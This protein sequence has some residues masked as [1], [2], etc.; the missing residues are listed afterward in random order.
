M[1]I[2]IDA[3]FLGTGTGLSYYTE[4]LIKNLAKLDDK[5]SYLI[6]LE[7]KYF[8]QFKPPAPNFKKIKINAPHYSLAEQTRLPSL[9]KKLK[10]DLVHFTNFN[11]PLLF[12]GLCVFTIQD[13]ILSVVPLKVN[14]FK[15]W[16]YKL[17]ISSAVRKGK[18]IIVPSM[19][20]K[21]DLQIILKVKSD[22][23]SIIYDGIVFPPPETS[24]KKVNLEKELKIKKPY[25]L[26]VGRFAPH[27]N[28]PRLLE[29]FHLLK[30][31]YNI[32]HQLV[33]VGS[34]DKD[35]LS[36][37]QKVVQL[38]LE[39]AVVFTGFL[40]DE[41]LFERL[42]REASLLVLPS[43]YEGFGLSVLDA[44]S[45]GV[46]IACSEISSLPEIAGKTAQF[47]NPQDPIDIAEKIDAVLNDNILREK[48]I[49]EGLKQY[50]K[51]PWEKTA[52]ETLLV[53]KDV[54]K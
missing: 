26:Y 5:N 1:R 12:R 32:N 22:K 23:I 4:N 47:F 25:I 52:Q 40:K 13:L 39:D 44:M 48:L 17:T 53:Y 9:I 21:K 36:L 6:I 3:R 45:R 33:L 7:N 30:N 15:K 18:K 24:L 43:L 29:A 11:H 42:Y 51:F 50:K 34:K 46:P 2:L 35:Y 10:P 41:K 37:K 28:L 27:K 19:N 54:I 14:F 20:T 38:N 8:D 31:K 16:M 49:R